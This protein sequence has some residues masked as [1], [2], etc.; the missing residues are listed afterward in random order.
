MQKIKL[1]ESDIYPK[2]KEIVDNEINTYKSML[3]I[4]EIKE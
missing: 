1:A 3:H 4:E 2:M